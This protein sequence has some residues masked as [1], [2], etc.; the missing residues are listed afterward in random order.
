MTGGG[1]SPTGITLDPAAPSHLWVVDNATDRVYQFDAAVGRTSGSQAASGSF[2][3]APGNTNPQDIAD[4]PVPGAGEPIGPAMS[5]A[6][7]FYQEEEPQVE[8]VVGDESAGRP[9]VSIVAV[10]VEP[11][12]PESSRSVADSSIDTPAQEFELDLDPIFPDPVYVG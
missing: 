7:D 12:K 11:W 10:A 1:G 6:G 8:T 5:L 9:A 2:A 3:L 4:P